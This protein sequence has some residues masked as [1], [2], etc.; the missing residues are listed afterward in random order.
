M[1]ESSDSKIEIASFCRVS[2]Y[3]WITLNGRA[4]VSCPF[5]PCTMEHDYVRAFIKVFGRC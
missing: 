2:P 3:I 4:C 1:F 5:G